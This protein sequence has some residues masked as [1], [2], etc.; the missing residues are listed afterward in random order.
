MSKKRRESIRRISLEC[1]LVGKLNLDSGISKSQ[2]SVAPRPDRRISK[3][4]LPVLS[5]KNQLDSEQKKAMP[6]E[7][8]RF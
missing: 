2:A 7:L 4:V 1:Y 6:T 8:D 3:G 5:Y